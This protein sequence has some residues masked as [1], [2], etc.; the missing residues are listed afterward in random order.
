MIGS[1]FVTG[2]RQPRVSPV[3][4]GLRSPASVG[5]TNGRRA[6]CPTGPQ[7]E[8]LN[9]G[10]RGLAC[11]RVP[12][13]DVQYNVQATHTRAGRECHTSRGSLVPATRRISQ[14]V[15]I[16]CI[17]F[18]LL[19]H[20]SLPAIRPAFIAAE[21]FDLG[22]MLLALLTLAAEAASDPSCPTLPCFP[23]EPP[24]P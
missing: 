3:S 19:P 10:Y 24:G 18:M 16:E 8:G 11:S 1:H 12:Q 5:W 22:R 20:T 17:Q 9:H 6:R 2:G 4:A 7:A 21:G 13:T 23:T 15:C 14:I